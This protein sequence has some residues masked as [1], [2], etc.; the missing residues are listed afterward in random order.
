MKKFIIAIVFMLFSILSYSQVSIGNLVRFPNSSLVGRDYK[1]ML[2]FCAINT[3]YGE[4]F[5]IS[6]RTCEPYSYKS[7]NEES[8]ILVRFA[9]ESVF[10]LQI[11]EGADVTKDFHTE[12]INSNIYE[13]YITFTLYNIEEGFLNKIINEKIPI[14]KIR[15]VFTNGDV[16]D[17]DIK[18]NYQEKLLDGLINSYTDA[19]SRNQIRKANKT[20]EDF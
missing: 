15:L 14:I 3:S 6:L 8:R 10:K 11:L 9:D 7:F 20:D 17:Y 18:P 1:P 12:V 16:T 5:L 2:G 4:D 19:I 13:H